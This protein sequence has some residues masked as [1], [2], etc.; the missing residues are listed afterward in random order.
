MVS[1]L[2]GVNPTTRLSLKAK[3]YL[4]C[5]WGEQSG[6]SKKSLQQPLGCVWIIL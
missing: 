2:L 1:A 4:L 3:K 6:Y 5:Q